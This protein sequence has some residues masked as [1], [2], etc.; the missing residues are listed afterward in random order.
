M[1]GKMQMNYDLII[2]KFIF[3]L[4]YLKR[5]LFAGEIS[6]FFLLKKIFFFIFTIKTL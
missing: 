1:H 6:L 2:D 3:D 5:I 4:F